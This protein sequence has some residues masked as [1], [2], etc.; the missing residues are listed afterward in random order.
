MIGLFLVLSYLSASPVY[1][2]TTNP[3]VM[4]KHPKNFVNKGGTGRAHCFALR[5]SESVGQFLIFVRSPVLAHS[6]PTH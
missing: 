4:P 1:S 2:Q 5:A 3:K 6:A